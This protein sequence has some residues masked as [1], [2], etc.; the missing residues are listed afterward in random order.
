MD[1]NSPQFEEFFIRLKRRR[2]IS[3]FL[4]LLRN[5][6]ISLI[7]LCILLWFLLQNSQ[8]QQYLAQK[9]TNHLS[10]ELN[11]DVTIKNLDID[12]FDKL[13]LE[14]FFIAD[15]YGDTLLFSK[16]LKVDM[17]ISI[18]SILRQRY[19]VDNISLTD[20]QINLKRNAGEPYNN[21]Q[22][23]IDFINSGVTEEE[24]KE[25]RQP[26]F[27]DLDG[28]YFNNVRFIDKDRMKG[29][30][31]V[32]DIPRAEILVDEIDLLENYI[33]LDKTDIYRP[34]VIH[35]LYPPQFPPALLSPEEPPIAEVLPL[36]ALPDTTRK[37]L[38]ISMNHLGLID[39]LFEFHNYRRYPEKTTPDH[40]FD[41]GHLR[42]RDIQI[43]LDDMYYTEEVCTM[44]LQN[45]SFEEGSGFVVEKLA[46]KD[47][48]VSN[49]TTILND[50]EMITPHSTLGDTLVFKYREIW[51]YNDFPNKVIMDARLHQ[52]RV[53]L[54]DI[55]M[56]APKMEQNAFFAQNRDEL[57]KI[58]GRLLGKVNNLRGKDL[59]IQIGNSTYFR[60]NFSSRN[61]NVK[62]EEALNF[63]VDRLLTDVSTL[64][65]LV[66]KFNPPANFDKLGKLNFNG[67]FDGFFVDFVAYGELVS[68][69]GTAEMDMRMDLRNGREG[70]KY[71]GG[72]SLLNFNL[73]E[74][75]GNEDLGMITFKSEVKEGKGLTLASV[76]A[77]LGAVIDQFSFRGYSYENV[78][79]D[80][81]LNR[82][83]FDGDLVVKDDNIDFNFTGTIK[84][85]DSIPEFDFKADINHL[86]LKKLNISEDDLVISGA[87]DLNLRDRTLSTMQGYAD[88]QH[89]KI[90]K[91]G[92]QEFFLDSIH[93][94][95]ILAPDGQRIFEVD[96][97]VLD[98]KMVGNFNIAQVPD[99]LLYY[100]KRNFPKTYNRLNI[101]EKEKIPSPSTFTYRI[102][103][104]DTKNFTELIHP[105]LD[106]LKNIYAAGF[107]DSESD[108][109][110]IDLFVPEVNYADMTFHDIALQFEGDHGE[111]SLNLEIYHSKIGNQDFEPVTLSG[112][113]YRD[114]FDFEVVAINWTTVLDNLNIQGELSLIDDLYQIQFSPS[115]LVILKDRWN[116]AK[117]NYLRFGKGFVETKNFE[118]TNGQRKISLN[119]LGEKGLVAKAEDFDFSLIDE[120]WVYEQMDF[121]GLFNLE[122]SARDLYNLKDLSLTIQAD[123]FE[124]NGDDWGS[125]RL[126]A[127]AKDLKHKTHAYLNITNGPQQLTGEGFYYPPV[128]TA[129]KEN[130]EN[131]FDFDFTIRKYPL[132]IVEYFVLNGLSNTI[133]E[134]G[135]Q[136]KINGTFKQPNFSGDILI[137]YGA[138]TID[139]LNTRYYIDR[140]SA[141]ISNTLFDVTGGQITDSLGNVATLYGG[142]TH[143]RMRDLGSNVILRSDRFLALNT[144]KAHNPIYYGVGLVKGE[145]RFSGRFN[146]TNI[147]IDAQ[148]L[149]GSSLVI[150]ISY[151][152]EAEEV[153]FIRFFDKDAEKEVEP[154]IRDELLGIAVDMK[155]GLTDEGT[156]SLIFDEKAGDIM[157]GAGVGDI[158]MYM[159]RSGEIT[160]YG[161]YNVTRGK[162]L[163]TYNNIF[164]KPFTVREGGTIRW[165]GDPYNAILNIEADYKGLSTPIYNFVAEYIS[166]DDPLNLRGEASQA[167]K[168]DLVMNISGELLQP[169]IEFEIE[170]PDLTGPLQN[171]ADSKLRVLNQNPNE[172]NRQV[173]GLFVFGGFLPP[174]SN[175][176][177]RGDEFVINTFTELI[178]SQL[179]ILTTELLSEFVTNVDIISG[180]GVDINYNTYQANV[181]GLEVLPGNEFGIRPEIGILDNRLTFRGGGDVNF[182]QAY[183][184]GAF[185]AGDI[186]VE[187]VITRD[188]RLKFR[189]Y[190]LYD[191]TITG[192]RD[193]RGAGLRYR[194]EGDSIKDLFKRRSEEERERLRKQAALEKARRQEKKRQKK[195]KKQNK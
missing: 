45:L 6:L 36:E 41:V 157:E 179:S 17:N 165:E 85:L 15:Q 131:Q 30:D 1:N 63:K 77:K 162:Y 32:I 111:N 156:V 125:F 98:A 110:N 116:L 122:T 155:L 139:Y 129:F 124:V 170:F 93:I 64:R 126:D 147:D 107:F 194:R 68:D 40:I 52:S 48:L 187:Y 195:A 175:L 88:A 83:S 105:E 67:R 74:W 55:M 10:K 106:T 140:Q 169:V 172:L 53:A 7:V 121:R 73:G 114:T 133:G 91:D 118:L 47:A 87:V 21:L 167:T 149:P 34:E 108:S 143:D 142:I 95:S 14:N 103:I 28:I 119:S 173:F 79:M 13:L 65:L 94:A 50:M 186:E 22:F 39:G 27:L 171:Y 174:T 181:G 138:L 58:D 2:R 163:F 11:T 84:K 178:T 128:S 184:D 81:R 16:E 113:T 43:D 24:P 144:T 164:N 23:I 99:A 4:K 102:D 18:L 160:M 57:L 112:E 75:S 90:I 5:L 136:V 148:S 66:P 135:A 44:E 117:D 61:L 20:A 190:Q 100:V 130:S 166:E 3:F 161:N 12:F 137:D 49:R 153:N 177:N 19:D 35:N 29:L 69:L 158:S 115:N 154:T 185:L 71:R 86:D 145:V 46:A 54:K 89:F 59:N 123:T 25:K 72:L 104:T 8:I 188:R 56:F 132:H 9:V 159:S 62:N 183:G 42:F 168:V 189:A 151:A 31:W 51:D 192:Q 60:G 182:G 180:I 193:K 127:V 38:K 109:I 141:T 80:G 33:K 120:L 78:T 150:P 26:P 152:E 134:F 176:Q 82:E 101:A 96:S 76:D 97:D 70:A 37:E 191:N 146:K 92:E